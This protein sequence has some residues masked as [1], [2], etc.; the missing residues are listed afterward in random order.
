MR[1]LLL[2]VC[3]VFYLSLGYS[4]TLHTPLGSANNKTFQSLTKDGNDPQD[5]DGDNGDGDDGGDSGGDSGSGDSGGDSG[6][7]SGGGDSDSGSDGDNSSPGGSG[8][9]GDSGS[10]DSGDDSG[11]GGS[12]NE[13]GDSGGDN[14][15]GDAGGDNSGGGD[16]GAGGSG[17]NGSD[18]GGS[19]NGGSDND[20]SGDD[21]SGDNGSDKGDD[22]G[23][24]SGDDNSGSG[25][26]S[27]NDNSSDGSNDKPKDDDKSK[28]EDRHYYVGTVNANDG[29]TI[30]MD[31]SSLKSSSPWVTILNTGMLF[32]A[33]GKWENNTFVAD[34][35]QV[36]MPAQFAYYRGPAKV[37]GLGTHTIEA[38]TNVKAEVESSRLLPGSENTLYLVAY[39]DGTKLIATP[40]TFP[41]PPAGSAVGWLELKGLFDGGAVVWE[42]AKA[43]P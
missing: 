41:V 14:S 20:N 12:D 23:N 8:S 30:I 7:N 17:D 27:G 33:Y 6:G 25:S 1:R 34:D 31:G 39:F 16:S 42:S 28:D 24:D 11:S 5:N 43:F 29:K 3:A 38:W 22:S 40:G 19:D 21:N 37:L 13:N 10:G 2:L 18:S 26:G 36:L 32:E 35:I 4:Q 9:G 15:G